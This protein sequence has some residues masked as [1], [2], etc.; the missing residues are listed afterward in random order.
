M[1]AEADEEADR[2][3]E[4]CERLGVPFAAGRADVPAI[5]RE[6]KI[7]FEEAGREAR[8][9]FLRQAK[10]AMGANAVATAHT[11]TDHVE[12]VLLHLV[13]G[14]GLR[15]LGGIRS[16]AGDLIRP[17]LIFDRRQTR[18]YCES[19][20]LWFHNDPAN[21]DPAFARSRLRRDVLPVLL[22]LNPG[23]LSSIERL[24]A[25]AREEDA[26][27]DGAAAA[28]LE[29]SE[30]PINGRLA[31]LTQDMEVAF[32]RISLIHLPDVLFR[33]ALR[34]SVE[35]LGG[36]LDYDLTRQIVE[37]LRHEESGS[38]TA[39]GGAVKL[40]WRGEAMHMY[41]DDSVKFKELDLVVPGPTFDNGRRWAIDS[42]VISQEQPQTERGSLEVFLDRDRI[43]GKVS[44][45][46]HATGDRIQP[47]GFSG[48]RKLSDL[49]SEAKLTS[50]A[51]KMLP[52]IVDEEGPIWV[53][54]VT[55]ADRVAT[56]SGS[57]NVLN[58]M[59][60]PATAASAESN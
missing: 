36:V 45:R 27:L 26:F 14:S 18:E 44:V 58:L 10:L 5:A 1:R 17:L 6:R 23:L 7:G 40:T 2:C 41:R 55:V 52:I 33:R 46:P 42:R 31:F 25:L 8:Y 54:A 16:R 30:I 53:P 60:R 9:E 49:L 59:L 37:G 57:T 28:S 51:R 13:R 24:A 15:G 35:T 43:V 21:L 32:D 39:P 50:L 19:R 34:L 22:E 56:Q 20:R 38:V 3:A 4:F 47:L 11:R 48:R 12:T 29:Q